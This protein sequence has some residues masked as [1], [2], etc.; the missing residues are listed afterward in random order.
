MGDPS[1]VGRPSVKTHVTKGEC[2]ARNETNHLKCNRF[3]RSCLTKSALAAMGSIQALSTCQNRSRATT[4]T[5]SQEAMRSASTI[6]TLILSG[7]LNGLSE[8]TLVI[9][10][11]RGRSPLAAYPSPVR[12]SIGA[13]RD[14]TVW[15]RR[16]D[17]N[18]RY[19]NSPYGGLANRWF[20]PLTHVSGCGLQAGRAGYI[21]E[22]STLQPER[23]LIRMTSRRMARLIDSPGPRTRIPSSGHCLSAALSAAFAWLTGSATKIPPPAGE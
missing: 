15:R 14:G 5:N 22:I 18:P 1:P 4:M 11:C 12:L 20:Q 8:S 7:N 9:S 21:G 10:A 23:S 6:S 17:S 16:R 2:S 19:G 3:P 13:E